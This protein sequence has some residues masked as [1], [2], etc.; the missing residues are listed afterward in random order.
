LSFE[1]LSG[2]DLAGED[3][4]SADL[5]NTMMNRSNLA[6]ANFHRTLLS[7]ASLSEAKLRGVNF[8]LADMTGV[9]L[10]F[11]DGILLRKKED[12]QYN[13]D[14]CIHDG[15][16]HGVKVICGNNCLSVVSV[17]KVWMDRSDRRWRDVMLPA[18]QK[19]LQDAAALE[20]AD[21]SIWQSAS[22][23]LDAFNKIVDGVSVAGNTKRR[24]HRKLTSAHL[25]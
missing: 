22:S 3:L 24:H 12:I 25:G 10:R 8:E 23:T 7:G 13:H 21:R 15:G 5:S 20:T 1:D 2:A 11:A 6:N 9:Q 14:L 4:Q 18:L 19:L 16:V 17:A